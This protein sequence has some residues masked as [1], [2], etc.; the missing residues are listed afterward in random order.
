MK[1]YCFMSALLFAVVPFAHGDW[2]SFRG[3]HGNGLADATNVPTTWSVNKNIKWKIPLP[4]PSNS[5]PIVVGDKVFTAGAIDQGKTRSLYCFQAGTGKRLWEKSVAFDRV[6]TTHKTNPYCSSTPV[7]DGK[8]VIVW[9]GS[10]GLFCYDLNGNE[11]WSNDL[12]DVVHI[13]GFGSSPIIH[14]D[15]VFLN[16]GPGKDTALM[17]VSLKTGKTLWQVSQPGVDATNPKKYTGSWSTPIIVKVGG[18]DQVVCSMPT[19]VIA[20]DVATG[21]ILWTCDGIASD[22]GNLAYASPLVAN[23]MGVAFGGFKGPSL[24]FKLGGSGN[25]TATHRVWREEQK[26]PQRIGSGVIVDGH[27]FISNADGPMALQCIELATGKVKWNQRLG[28]GFWGSVVQA[29][30]R[31]Y[32]T[33]QRGV[34]HVFA[35]DS[36]AFNSIAENALEEPSN[37]TPAIVSGRI[38]IQTHGHLW[39]IESE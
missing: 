34:T 10:A 3:P 14:D 27:I 9:H 12:G 38:Y 21:D 23:G 22:R 29:D 39:C 20:C 31:L 8:V 5:S 25:I 4:G 16:H 15:R 32:G 11:I 24:G 18:K 37:S 17:A 2:P 19:R 30:G 33:N 1:L 7:S 13:W 36:G 26:Q 35:A 28:G 6:E